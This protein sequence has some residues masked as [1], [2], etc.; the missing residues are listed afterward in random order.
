M[1]GMIGK[2]FSFLVAATGGGD[3]VSGYIGIFVSMDDCKQDRG[4]IP[5]R[6]YTLRQF[7]ATVTFAIFFYCDSCMV[8][9]I[10]NVSFCP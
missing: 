7:D 1:V 10:A 5:V 3:T 4:K 2:A 8:P 9:C 6:E